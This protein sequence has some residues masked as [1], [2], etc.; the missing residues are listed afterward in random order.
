MAELLSSLVAVNSGD[1]VLPDYLA[2]SIA[3]VPAA[4]AFLVE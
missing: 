2:K 1:S 4:F 3:I